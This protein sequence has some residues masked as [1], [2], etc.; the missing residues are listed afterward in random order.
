MTTVFGANTKHGFTE[1]IIEHINGL[2][3]YTK[4]VNDE[5]YADHEKHIDK[6]M[7]RYHSMVEGVAEYFEMNNYKYKMME[8]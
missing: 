1:I 5:Y 8:F 6:T 2:T 7:D 4:K 3:I